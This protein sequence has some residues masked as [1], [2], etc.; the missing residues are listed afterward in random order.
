MSRRLTTARLSAAFLVLAILSG[1]AQ[2]LPAVVGPSTSGD[3]YYPALGN[4]GYDVKRYVIALDILPESNTVA[5]ETRIEAIATEQLGAFYL[6]FTGLTIDEAQV[7]GNAAKFEQEQAE[8]LLTPSRPL[9]AGRDFTVTIRYHGQP[10]PAPD[11][12]YGS[13]GLGWA[14]DTDGSI[15][16]MNEPSGARGWFPANDHPRDK[17]AF[18]FE[19]TVPKP[20]IVVASGEPREQSDLGDRTRFIFE[21]AQ[22]TTTYLTSVNVGQYEVETLDGPNGVVIRNYF[23]PEYYE[24]Q[25]THFRK[26]PEM[27]AYFSSLFGPY[28]FK[29][30]ASVIASDAHP[31]CAGSIGGAEQHELV[32]LC[33]SL[34]SAAA[35]VIAHE[36]AHQWFG[37]SVSLEAWQDV[38]LKEGMATYAEWLWQTRER[39]LQTLDKVAKVYADAYQ[40]TAPV[41]DPGANRL[42]N[43]EPYIGGALVIHALRKQVGEEAFFKLLRTYLERYRDGTASS[44]EFIAVAEEVSG[45]ELSARFDEWLNKMGEPA[46]D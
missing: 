10:G 32:V 29:A 24:G 11:V 4:G 38:W 46:I 19:V 42:Y 40:A 9:T 45:Q 1:C 35:D 2:S 22:P 14:H 33:P 37:N 20:W 8:L 21:S 12:V 41:G 25:R 7:N 6:D 13:E 18:R 27:I 23:P 16:A 44:E 26:A 34:P 3:S 15:N 31:L 17:A 39:D 5:G 30:Y 43:D 28:P 36:I